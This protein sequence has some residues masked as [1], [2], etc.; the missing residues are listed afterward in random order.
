[1]AIVDFTNP[2]AREWY[3]AKLGELVDMGVDCFKTDFGERIPTDVRYF[4][5]S[6]PARMHNYYTLH[7]QRARVRAP[8]AEAREGRRD[9]IR[10]LRH[11]GR[12]EISGALGRRLLRPPSSPWP[13]AC[14]AGS[15][16][17]SRGFGFWSHDIGGFEDLPRRRVYKSW[18]AF[19][20]LSS[21]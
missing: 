8:G 12:P 2:G 20:L 16:S 6:D 4:D 14:A 17:A 10:A 7:V 5:G 21:H 11:R 13:R 19:G 18:V 1:M 3:S 9:R 15:R